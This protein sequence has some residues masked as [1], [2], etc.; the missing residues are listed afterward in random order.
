MLGVEFI[1]ENIL[2]LWV[3]AGEPIPQKRIA[4]NNT[5]HRKMSISIQYRGQI[6]NSAD[7]QALTEE[8][9]DIAKIM[10]WP[11][12]VV[13]ESWDLPPDAHF[14]SIPGAGIQIVGHT[15]LK[16]ICLHP[17]PR[18]EPLWFVFRSD[19]IM[20]SPFL[21]ALDAGEGYPPKSAWLSTETQAAGPEAH[22]AIARLLHRIKNRYVHNLEVR[23]PSGF[24]ES[25]DENRLR[26]FF[27]ALFAITP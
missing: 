5:P 25:G 22:T 20:S 23:D 17:H 13:D 15:G 2:Y 7:V 11:C 18:C 12:E 19:G 3:H 27:D 8:V 16:G 21:L 10:R 26:L 4:G 9:E 1:I 14:E 24:W 6:T